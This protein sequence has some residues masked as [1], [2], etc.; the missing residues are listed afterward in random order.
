MAPT[1][2]TENAPEGSQIAY[3]RLWFNIIASGGGHATVVAWAVGEVLPT[4]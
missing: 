1:K 2:S 3:D 4:D